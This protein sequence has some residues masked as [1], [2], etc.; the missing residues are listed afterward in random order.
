[1]NPYLEI[2]RPFTSFLSAFGV[3]V[4]G[5]VAGAPVDMALAMAVLASF[6]ISGAGIV[7]ND[8]YDLKIDRIN[9]PDRPLPS[10][11]IRKKSALLFAAALFAA[12]IGLS[13]FL[14]TYCLGIA[15]LNT[16]LELIYAKKLKQVAI[17]GNAVDSWF[18]ASTFIFGA[19]LTMDFSVVWILSILAFMANMGREIFG[20]MEDLK[21]DS[22]MELHTL[23]IIVG[24]RISRITGSFFILSAV[25][26]SALPYY[27]GLLNMNYL[28]MIALADTLFIFSIF[29]TPKNNQKTTKIA[30][31]MALIAFLIGAL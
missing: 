17:L 6:M 4:G 7:L 8:Y 12:G 31:L 3:F 20:D 13:Y 9:A 10:G 30:M 23:P 1:M 2:I 21:G 14:N 16:I 22:A 24:N 26:L 25:A 11:R 19:C 5:A 18:V 28:A 15:V 29:Q 27:L